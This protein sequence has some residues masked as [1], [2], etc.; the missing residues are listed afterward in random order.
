MRALA[1]LPVLAAVASCNG[2]TGYQLVQ[3][4]AAASGPSDAAK[5]QPYTFDVAAGRVTLTKATLHV[6]ALYLTQ[7]SPQSGGG[8][9]PCTLPGTYN[10]A[11]VAEVRGG[12]DVDLLDPSAQQ[13][14]VVGDG[15][16]IP[17]ATGQ[18]WLMHDDVNASSDPTAI[19]T[20]QGTFAGAGTSF[21]FFANITIDSNRTKTPSASDPLPGSDPIC[22]KRI[23]SGIPVSLEVAQGGTLLLRVSPR[24]LFAS[25]PFTDLPAFDKFNSGCSQDMRTDRCFTNDDTNTSSTTLFA[26]LTGD[27]PYGFAF[28]PP[29]Q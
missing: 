22:R 21:S 24:A 28:L 20:L 3:F 25:V 18:V 9:S 23:V 1:I 29:A 6:G 26:N 27:G 2:S 19:L 17:P 10:G 7:S 5:G 14:P 4:Y 8:P 16:T 13:L 15:D 12:G 11:Y